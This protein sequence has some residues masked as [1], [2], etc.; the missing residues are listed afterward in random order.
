MDS[1]S[2]SDK[3]DASDPQQLT[4]IIQTEDIA[5]YPGLLTPSDTRWDEKAWVRGYER[6][7]YS[8]IHHY[9][10]QK[11]YPANFTKVYKHVL[12]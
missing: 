3:P 5:L 8:V 9:L 4:T 2:T 6:Y 10:S 7:S 12:I 11:S 1:A